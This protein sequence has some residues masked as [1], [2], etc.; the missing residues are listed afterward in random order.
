MLAKEVLKEIPQ[1]VVG[2]FQ[3]RGIQPNPKQIQDKSKIMVQNLM[4][5]QLKK[6]MN[7]HETYFIE[8]KIKFH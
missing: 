4:H 7:V 5:N 2:Y 8:R 6:A 1:Q 3:S